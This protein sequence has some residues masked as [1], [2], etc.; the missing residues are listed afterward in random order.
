MHELIDAWSK[1]NRDAQY[2]IAISSASPPQET[3]VSME[4]YEEEVRG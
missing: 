4:G 2:T 1:N 3:R